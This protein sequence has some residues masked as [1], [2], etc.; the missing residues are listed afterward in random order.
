MVLLLDDDESV[1]IYMEHLLK[2]YGFK[3]VLYTNPAHCLQELE[4]KKGEYENTLKMIICDY[5]MPEMDGIAFKKGLKESENLAYADTLPFVML[6]SEN[7]EKG[8]E[9]SRGTGVNAWMT[10]PFMPD[11]LIDIVIRFVQTKG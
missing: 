8:R 9:L 11:K 4:G 5:Y 3:S 6:S 1:L 7:L 2:S 10:K